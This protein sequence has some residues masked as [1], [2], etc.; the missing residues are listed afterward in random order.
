LEGDELKETVLGKTGL[1]VQRL[2]F[3]GI[4]IQRVSEEEAIAIVRRC[5]ELGINYFDTARGYT[6]SEERIGKALEGVREKVIIATKSGCRTRD[7][8]LKELETSLR[9]LRTDY[10]D[11][12]QLHGVSSKEVWDQ[13]RAPKGALEALC[14]ARDQG[15]IRH[16]GITSHD[17]KLMLGIVTEGI[18][19]TLLIPYNFL[20]T[21]SGED[22]LPLCRKLGVGTIIM[23]PFGGGAFTNTATA[24]K[25]LLADRNVN[26]VVPGMMTVQEVEENVAVAIGSHRLTVEDHRLIEKDRKELGGEYCR[27]CDYCQPCPQ[28]IPI[29]FVLRTE[30]QF[31][32]RM[33]W[34]PH[35]E[36]QL[37]VAEEL[38]PTCRKCG[39]CE[40][41]C[42]YHLLIRELLPVKIVSLKR[43]IEMKDF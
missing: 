26:V 20:A 18:F 14:E 32:R 23:K 7:E 42:P 8:V 30:T 3:G 39:E 13:V 40:S 5:Y 34:S 2:G 28:K 36:G 17:P 29:S 19:E 6:V 33:G 25:F 41:R 38:V 22:L 43:R 35:L 37:H 21:L 15:K 27:G 9:N 24:L 4:P 1:K 12:Y 31:L 11:V 10:I 16:L